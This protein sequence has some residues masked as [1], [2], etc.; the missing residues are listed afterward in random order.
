MG[1][2][3]LGA[4]R[5][6]ESTPC[7]TGRAVEQVTLEIPSGRRIVALPAGAR[8]SG[9]HFDYVSRWSLE[10]QTLTVQRE[11]TTH[12]DQPLCS[13]ATRKEAAAALAAIR[14]DHQTPIR[15]VPADAAS[16]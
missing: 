16:P 11:F 10:G 1:L 14:Q 7:F 6:T 4:L 2:L 12:V 5:D 9:A 3:R 13:G 15:I 8:I